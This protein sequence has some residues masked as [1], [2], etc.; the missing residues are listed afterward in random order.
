MHILFITSEVAPYSGTG[1]NAEV[2]GALPKALRSLDHL[3]TVVSPLYPGIDPASH[4][5]ARRLSKIEVTVDGQSYGFE[6]Y[7]GRNVS[8]VNL[9]FLRH[10]TLFADAH[11]FGG[12]PKDVATRLAAF[13]AATVE[14][15]DAQEENVDVVHGHGAVGAA[16]VAVAKRKSVLGLHG[17]DAPTFAP[18]LAS[19]LGACATDRGGLLSPLHAGIAAA[20]RVTSA[21]RSHAEE[22]AQRLELA[23][24]K[25]VA[26]GRGIDASVWNPLTDAHLPARF[27]PVD[28]TGKD[29]C[30]RELQRELDLPTRPEVPLLAIDAFEETSGAGLF[31]KIASKVL[32]NDVQIAVA[33]GPDADGALVAVFEELWDRWPERIA[34]RTA[35][36]A[37]FRHRLVGAA[38]LLLVAPEHAPAGGDEMRAQRYGALPIVHRTGALAD[39]V[40]D[41]DA[42]LETGTGFAFDGYDADAIL[43][44]VQRALSATSNDAFDALRARVMRID[45]SWERSARMHAALYTELTEQA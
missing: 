3:V 42:K 18:E 39:G 35:V 4:S 37:E 34:V 5:L 13:A 19:V 32:R 27:D 1:A 14:V 17:T 40:I 30:K 45:Q 41:C 23:E 10:E 8:G 29:R 2:A 44:A 43:A 7:T 9:V 20:S 26:I 33:F 15:A 11:F 12:A 31:A 28:L 36:D 21:S 25:V 16:A 22:L 24:E 38:D 6:M